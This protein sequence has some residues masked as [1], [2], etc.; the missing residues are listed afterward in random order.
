MVRHRATPI[1]WIGGHPI[2]V[3]KRHQMYATMKEL[4]WSAYQHI[5]ARE[6]MRCMRRYDQLKMNECVPV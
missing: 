6:R 2:S 1:N 3:A 4:D 5:S